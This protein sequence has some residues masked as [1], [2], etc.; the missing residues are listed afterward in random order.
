MADLDEIYRRYGEMVFRFLLG[1]CHDE[2]TAQDLMQETFVRAVRDI[3]RF[4]G[5]CKVTTWLCQ[6]AKHLWYQE[7]ER[8]KRKGAVPLEE[9]LVQNGESMEESLYL[10]EE[11]ME[12]FRFIHHLDE[13]SKEVLLLRITGAFSFREIGEIFQRNENWARVTFY[14]AKQKIA[15]M[16]KMRKEDE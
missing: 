11:K 14:R 10:K 9:T 5:R 1:L 6:I 3:H 13:T 4:D 15:Q 7:L 8:R 16:R 2:D 12:T